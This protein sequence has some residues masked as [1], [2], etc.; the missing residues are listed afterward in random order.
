MRLR[1][2]D[3]EPEVEWAQAEREEDERRRAGRG[4]EAR[5]VAARGYG[6]GRECAEREERR[7]AKAERESRQ[8]VRPRLGAVQLGA[9]AAC[10]PKHIVQDRVE[11]HERR[12]AVR[13]RVSREDRHREH[14][15]GERSRDAARPA[16]DEER[17]VQAHVA[18]GKEELLEHERDR[19][20]ER[21]R[22]AGERAERE[23]QCRA[24]RARRA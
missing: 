11:R 14:E 9:H 7:G 20:D 2:E 8:V 4:A 18:A 24:K 19:G 23:R 5:R 22:P 13:E 21:K 15:R 17:R 3:A 12:A 10:T 16:P 1:G 6:D